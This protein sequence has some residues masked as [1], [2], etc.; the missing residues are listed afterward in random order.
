MASATILIGSFLASGSIYFACSDPRSSGSGVD[1][2]R[3]SGVRR[4]RSRRLARVGSG[5]ADPRDADN[6][7]LLLDDEYD[8]EDDEDGEYDDDDGDGEGE[9]DD[10]EG[11]FRNRNNTGASAASP[12]LAPAPIVPPNRPP[13]SRLEALRCISHSM[14]WGLAESL[15]KWD[16]RDLV[17][18]LAYLS[19]RRSWE[20]GNVLAQSGAPLV[21]LTGTSTPCDTANVSNLPKDLMLRVRRMLAF[22]MALRD[23]Q[24]RDKHS[25]RA[26]WTDALSLP[27]EACV[28]R[29]EVRAGMLR[30]AYALFRDEAHKRF[31]LVIRGTHTMKDTMTCLMGQTLPHH[32][33]VR[34]ADGSAR[35]VMGYAHAGMLTSARFILAQVLEEL[36]ARMEA[37]PEM[38]L[39]LVGHS[40]GGATAALLAMLLRERGGPCG[41]ATCFT[42]ACPA[43]VT[44]ELARACA[45]YVFSLVNNTDVIPMFSQANMEHLREEVLQSSWYDDLVN[46]VHRIRVL[47]AIQSLGPLAWAGGTVARAA[48]YSAMASMQ[49]GWSAGTGVVKAAKEVGYWV[50]GGIKHCVA[51]RSGTPRAGADGSSTN[52]PPQR[53]QPS[54]EEANEGAGLVLDDV[55]EIDRLEEDEEEEEEQEEGKKVHKEATS[56]SRARASV[57]SSASL[58][59]AAGAAA[60]GTASTDAT[61]TPP[62][63]LASARRRAARASSPPDRDLGKEPV[64]SSPSVPSPAPAASSEVR[65]A[66]ALFPAG[67]LYH[68]AK[69]PQ[70]GGHRL[71]GPVSNK[72]YTSM[73]LCRDMVS[74][75]MIWEYEKSLEGVLAGLNLWPS[76]VEG[77]RR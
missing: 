63:A 47:R 7:D 62:P 27:S 65:H 4:S 56:T 69:C 29:S 31:V 50:G 66:S 13:S 41:L 75:H 35:L 21:Q 34:D 3:P 1:G 39:C 53:R 30:P 64:Q 70:G 2:S 24:R 18:G 42:F 44:E 68:M 19:R 20:P 33:L 14:R 74:D 71:Y 23:S 54:A 76:D 72:L 77:S 49:Y 61:S 57:S 32:V 46:D 25:N 11:D 5:D 6:R 73:R 40:L 37:E 22:C 26:T 45:S 38:E 43:C 48:G 28:V 58:S 55:L 9:Y 10:E 15:G 8:D 36:E 16:I 12:D 17:I 52:S 51:P 67:A 60:A 59:T